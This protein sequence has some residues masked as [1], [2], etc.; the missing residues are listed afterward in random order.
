MK[1]LPMMVLVAG[2]AVGAQGDGN[3]N[4]ST[5]WY[6]SPSKD[7]NAALPLGNGRLGA[8]V[9]GGIEEERLQV[10]DDTFWTGKPVFSKAIKSEGPKHLPEI[11]R[12]VFEN[13]WQEAQELWG[14]VMPDGIGWSKYQPVG[15][16]LLSFPGHEN[17][18]GYRRDLN[19]DMATATVSYRHKGVDYKRE[20]FSSPVDDVLV[21]RISASKKGSLNF[22][23][24]MVGSYPENGNKN[25]FTQTRVL[26]EN[27]LRLAGRSSSGALHY[28]GQLLAKAK[29]GRIAADSDRLDIKGAT[30]VTLVFSVGTNFVNFKDVSGNAEKKCDDVIKRCGNKSF[31]QFRKDHIAEHQRLFRRVHVLLPASESSALPTNERLEAIRAGGN[32][33]QLSVLLFQF[34]RYLMVSSSRPG[35]QVPNLQGIWNDRMN[36]PWNCMYT[37]NINIEMNYWPVNTANLSECINPLVRFL[38][39]VSEAGRVNARDKLGFHGWY[40][41]LNT[42]IWRSL[43]PIKGWSFW[44]T[45]LTGGTW[46]C[47]A[48]W[49]HYAFNCDREYL[50][51]IYPLLK[52]SCE[53]SLDALVKHPEQPY[54]VT[55][56]SMSPENT[57]HRMK[58]I[59]WALQPSIC[60]G[61][62]M[63]MQLLRDLFTNFAE[64]SETLGKDKGLRNRVLVARGKLAP[65]KIGRFGQVQEWFDDWDDPKDVHRHVSHLYG[66]YPG[67]QI[68]LEETPE[69]VKAAKVTIEKRGLISTGWSMAWKINLYA[70]MRDAETA[71]QLIR[72]NFGYR[73]TAKSKGGYS[74]GVTDNLFCSHPPMQIDGNFGFTAGFAEMLIQSHQQTVRILPCL[75]EEWSAGS[76]KGLKARG[77]F[78]C[79]ASW[80][81]GRVEAITVASTLGG[82]LNLVANGRKVSMQTKKGRNYRFDDSL[83]MIGSF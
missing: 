80:K 29:G 5:L 10:N 44:D 58:D 69:L 43:G 24:T 27:S 49:D 56:P 20:Y 16:I 78:I 42:D 19:L 25:K 68:T 23:A 55:N 35:V 4:Q 57:H 54:L 28:R 11:R 30:S 15:D 36:P 22:S 71:H 6:K 67:D 77:G 2:L 17:V 82:K 65:T 52:G 72:Y 14:R 63:D 70:R 45:W 75:P 53:F 12:L 66:L 37:S 83:K 3:E 50:E 9:F 31:D 21:M 64:A 1:R 48:L 46:Y 26:S 61:A 51:R 40:M 32:D 62:T 59:K 39:E 74:G 18:T 41:S 8:M 60:A 13:K 47:N 79:D 81:K 33:P 73:D 38:E 7:W 76:F 34:G